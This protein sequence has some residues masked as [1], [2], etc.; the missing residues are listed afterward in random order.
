MRGYTFFPIQGGREPGPRSWP[1]CPKASKP[2]GGGAD[3]AGK[4]VERDY[5]DS[6]LGSVQSVLLEQEDE[7]GRLTGYTG[8]YIHTAVKGGA[9]GGIV[10]VLPLKREE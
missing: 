6:A 2:P 1:T 9:Q 10:N 3:R 5:I 4:K 8:T 7:A